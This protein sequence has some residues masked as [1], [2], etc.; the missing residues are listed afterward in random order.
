MADARES[1]TA[2]KMVG[3]WG[4]RM[5]GCW[6]VQKVVQKA[7]KMAEEMVILS[8]EL[9]ALWKAPWTVARLGALMAALSVL[10]WAAHWAPHWVVMKVEQ[11][12]VETERPSAVVKAAY[13]G[14]KRADKLDYSWAAW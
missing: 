6:A 4:H 1:Q 10:Y 7:Q 11:L 5:D 12:A 2:G 14:L 9:K 13:L 8:A 3:D